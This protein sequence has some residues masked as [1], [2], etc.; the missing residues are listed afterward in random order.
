MSIV[1]IRLMLWLGRDF[2]PMTQRRPAHTLGRSDFSIAL[3]VGYGQAVAETA[4]LETDALILC[5]IALSSGHLVAGDGRWRLHSLEVV[6]LDRWPELS[7][8]HKGR[9]VRDLGRLDG[10]RPAVRSA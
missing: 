5:L 4:R 8:Q 2:N 10:D 3:I 6:D 9:Y 1:Q 7:M